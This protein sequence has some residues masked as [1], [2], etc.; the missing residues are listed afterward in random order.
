[1][2]P[3]MKLP[4]GATLETSA[5]PSDSGAMKLP[6]G[7]RIEQP[8]TADPGYWNTLLSDLKN[9]PAGMIALVRHPVDTAKAAVGQ[10]DF[11]HP[12]NSSGLL[13][14]VDVLGNEWEHGHKGEA[15]AH[16]TE[17]GL[18]II[19]KGTGALAKAAAPAADTAATVVRGAAQGLKANAGP[20]AEAAAEGGV[21]GSLFGHPFET[22]AFRAA[23]RTAKAI[24]QGIKQALADRR[25]AA[26]PP[27]AAEASPLTPEVLPPERQLPQGAIQMPP[28]ADTSGLRLVDAGRGVARDPKTGRMFRVYSSTDQPLARTP[29]ASAPPVAQEAAPSIPA[30][31]GGEAPA[32]NPAPA[33]A[34][35]EKALSTLPN[36]QPKP[37]TPRNRAE[38]DQQFQQRN[39]AKKAESMARMLY[40]GG[41]DTPGAGLSLDDV[42]AMGDDEWKQLA[43]AAKIAD[44]QKAGTIS[45][46]DLGKIN[47]VSAPS[48]E[49]QRLVIQRVERYWQAHRMAQEGPQAPGGGMGAMKRYRTDYNP[50]ALTDQQI[51]DLHQ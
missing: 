30:A 46:S 11:E 29:A 33:K 43:K 37:S 35:V 39:R 24:V 10:V 25:A 8:A 45:Q 40:Y 9:V 26:A 13:G 3:A 1:M 20:I 51:Q 15:L 31:A 12:E 42:K 23:P 49:T 47:G 50:A 32:D 2:T 48:P 27:V 28:A 18:P 22:A 5:P 44:L 4:P 17:L 38:A 19:F 34:D 21:T 14:A 7:A 41:S 36:D 16:L 6:P